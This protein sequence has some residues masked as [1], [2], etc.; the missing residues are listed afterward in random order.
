[1]K[2]IRLKPHVRILRKTSEFCKVEGQTLQEGASDALPEF[3]N[4]K[5]RE[6]NVVVS[7]IVILKAQK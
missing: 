5:E 7:S 6:E 3:G 1:M 2:L 4:L